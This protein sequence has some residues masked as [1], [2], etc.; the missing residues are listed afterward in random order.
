MGTFTTSQGSCECIS[1]DL[2]EANAQRWVLMKDEDVPLF[3][4]SLGHSAEEFVFDFQ[5]ANTDSYDNYY[6]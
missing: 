3:P 1:E 4:C 6:K 2:G 5:R